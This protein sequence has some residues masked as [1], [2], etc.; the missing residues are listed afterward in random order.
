MN[1]VCQDHYN[2]CQ[3][4]PPYQVSLVTMCWVL[5][6]SVTGTI[7]VISITWDAVITKHSW[8]IFCLIPRA[9]RS[10]YH[11]MTCW[12]RLTVKTV[13]IVCVRTGTGG[14]VGVAGVITSGYYE[15][16]SMSPVTT[17]CHSQNDSEGRLKVLKWFNCILATVS[18]FKL[19]YDTWPQQRRGG[20]QLSIVPMVGSS[21]AWPYIS[22]VTTTVTQF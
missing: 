18:V 11:L 4:S 15:H 5:Q 22:P 13:L 7:A 17:D 1:Y 10:T 19:N 20:A 21:V 16:G 6:V 14:E 12:H 9:A 3:L 8:S 2:H